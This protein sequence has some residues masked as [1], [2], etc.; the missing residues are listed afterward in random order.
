M[1]KK[2]KELPCYTLSAEAF[3]YILTEYPLRIAI[4]PDLTDLQYGYQNR[5]WI[6]YNGRDK[7]ICLTWELLKDDSIPS[8]K[9]CI[10]IRKDSQKEPILKSITGGMAWRTMK[11]KLS[12]YYTEKQFDERMK[13]FESEYDNKKNQLHYSYIIDDDKIHKYTDSI[14]YDING[15]YAQ[16]IIEIF[17][18][19]EKEILKLYEERKTNPINKA[20][21]NYFIGMFCR[22]GYRKTFNYV[23][24]KIRRFMDETVEKCDGILLYAN[25]DGFAVSSPKG[26]PDNVGRQLGQFKVEYE[27]DIY[28]YA[29]RNYWI[30]QCGD[31]IK[32]SCLWIARKQ[33]DLRKGKVVNYMRRRTGL[34]YVAENIEYS[35]VEI[36][37]C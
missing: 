23:V 19:A 5:Y 26:K 29:G 11:N 2:K 33:I 30:I 8:W 35:E 27:G 28:T 9:Q 7:L 22:K 14:K 36:D 31:D 10:C 20:Y 18:K 6:Y 21:I 17:P 25:T 15:A 32:G 34:V 24:Q 13:M 1:N 4:E 12:K 37:E 3:E 16:A